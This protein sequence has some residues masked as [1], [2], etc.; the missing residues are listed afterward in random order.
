MLS[1]IRNSSNYP[2]STRRLCGKI[3]GYTATAKTY[4]YAPNAKPHAVRRYYNGLTN[5]L[6]GLLWDANGNLAQQ[7]VYSVA[8]NATTYL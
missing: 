1:K 6:Y 5:E 3:Q 2:P 8:N 7:T 4:A